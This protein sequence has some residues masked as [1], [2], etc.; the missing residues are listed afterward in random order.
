MRVFTATLSTESN[1]FSPIPT[2]R[3]SFEATAWFPAGT[4]PDRP[5]PTTAQII[6]LREVAGARGW[7]VIEGLAT[8]AEPAAPVRQADYEA[9]RDQILGELE[10]AMP[11][12]MVVLGLHGAMLAV[13]CEDCEGD[14]LAR[15]RRLVGPDVAIGAELDPH[16]HLTE[17]MTENADVLVAY[18]EYPHTDFMERARELVEIT[19]AAAEGRARPVMSVFDCRMIVTA[20]T[21]RE[22]MRGFVD[23]V[24]E[25]EGKDGV[26]SISIVHCFPFGDVPSIGARLL[27][28]TDGQPEKG[29]ALAERLGRE[30][31][32]MRRQVA[33]PYLG[34]E[35]AI[36][37]VL[38]QE[39][40]PFVLAD[41]ADNAGGGAPS[42]NTSILRALIERG[43]EGAAVGPIWDPQAVRFCEGFGEGATFRLRF[44]GKAGLA[45]GQPI[46][47]EVTVLKLVKSLTQSFSGAIIP[48]GDAAAIRVGG[49]DVLLNTNRTQGRAPDMFANC[50]IDPTVKKLLVVKSTNHFHAAFAPIAKDILYVDADGPLARDYRRVPF[51]RLERDLYPFHPD[52]LGL[53]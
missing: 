16:C 45:S 1:S 19:A 10:A 23:R 33:P 21:S 31:Y 5:R 49:V 18:K 6:A 46:D 14:L 37:H 51:T 25:L 29:Q 7:T 11:V 4:H 32:A 20:P 8:H 13:G 36:D 43:A 39:G 15:V 40:G 28:V 42:D 34:V 38:A 17:A 50:G 44:G 48:L 12:D 52:P 35:E 27:V 22:P 26:L 41:P 2:T 53:D 30:F 3:A 24:K 9:L 47:A